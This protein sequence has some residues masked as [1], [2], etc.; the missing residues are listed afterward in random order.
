MK[1][2]IVLSVLAIA[3]SGEAE[4]FFGKKGGAE[5]SGHSSGGGGGLGGLENI[6]A[7]VS[8]TLIS[9]D[10]FTSQKTVPYHKS[11]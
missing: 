6:L 8:L 5:S 4:A 2:I 7:Y 3:F 9:S 10:G 1:L 11:C